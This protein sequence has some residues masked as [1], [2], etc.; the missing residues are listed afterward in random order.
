MKS[1][2]VIGYAVE[3]DLLCVA[4]AESWARDAGL[5]LGDVDACVDASVSPVFADECNEDLFC[6]ACNSQIW[7]QG[8][9]A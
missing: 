8:G 2:D 4:C 7:E 6:G 1:Y 3:G 5:D 9:D